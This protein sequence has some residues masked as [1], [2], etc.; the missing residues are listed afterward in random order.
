[1]RSRWPAITRVTSPAV[2]CRVSPSASRTTWRGRASGAST[3]PSGRSG[4]V[5]GRSAI[6]PGTIVT[7]AGIGTLDHRTAVSPDRSAD[8]PP[9]GL[10]GIAM[11][12]M[13][14]PD[15]AFAEPA[16]VS[17]IAP[18]A[19][20]SMSGGT[21][22]VLG[23]PARSTRWLLGSVTFASRSAVIRMM[24][25]SI[26]NWRNGVVPSQTTPSLTTGYIV[27][28]A[29]H[30]TYTPECVSA[31]SPRIRTTGAY[32]MRPSPVTATVK[33]PGTRVRSTQPATDGDWPAAATSVRQ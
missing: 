20:C 18:A 11:P 25:G 1:M 7:P 15:V 26:E 10:A 16:L 31:G 2:R 19:N 28:G 17:R 29:A 12:G 27:C 8:S 22:R 5:P 33:G 24:N 14:A 30:A 32:T 13:F 23:E 21:S 6:S 9:D 3:V 4:A